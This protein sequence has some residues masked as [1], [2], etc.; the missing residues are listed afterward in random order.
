MAK[1]PEKEIGQD[2][3]SARISPSAMALEE[4]RQLLLAPEQA[5]L[6]KMK[7]RLDALNI[8]PTEV[9]D[10]LSE[11]IRYQSQ[12]N[13]DLKDSLTP[14]IQD[15]FS[16]TFPG[17]FKRSVRETPGIISD[18]VSPILVPTLNKEFQREFP[19]T[20]LRAVKENPNA[21]AEAVSPIIMSAL[22]KWIQKQIEE[23]VQVV[24]QS[25]IGELVQTVNQALE[26]ESPIQRLKW[27]WQAFCTGMP[28][29]DIRQA[30]LFAHFKVMHV[31]LIHAKTGILLNRISGRDE[32]D[33]RED[34]VASMLGAVKK[35]LEDIGEKTDPNEN[36]RLQ[37][38]EFQKKRFYIEMGQDALIAV[39]IKQDPPPKWRETIRETLRVI[40]QKFGS[41]LEKFNGNMDGYEQTTPFL[42]QILDSPRN[43][44]NETFKNKKIS[45]SWLAVAGVILLLGYW[46][47]V[48]IYNNYIWNK[49]VGLVQDFDEN[50][51][52]LF[53]TTV[54]KD[55]EDKLSIKG[56]LAP[57]FEREEL[58]TGIRKIGESVG[59]NPHSLDF[60]FTPFFPLSPEYVLRLA[61]ALLAPPDSVKLL[62]IND[63][64]L[65]ASGVASVAW[66]NDFRTRAKYLP[67]IST[68]KEEKL[69][70]RGQRKMLELKKTIESFEL[71][72]P[73]G[74]SI[75]NRDSDQ[76][77]ETL[78]KNIVHLDRI[79]DEIKGKIVLEIHGHA[80]QDG[81]SELNERISLQRAKNLKN[82]LNLFELQNIEIRTKAKGTQF[83]EKFREKGEEKNF[84]TNRRIS[85]HVLTQ[86]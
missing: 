9:G 25:K 44:E 38:L 76:Q 61:K 84:M 67:G 55:A 63:G 71:Y 83:L 51:V 23:K 42:E 5:Q 32:T 22:G 53:I 4:L 66:I 6:G 8:G 77:I 45:K 48:G 33:L 54:G 20:F 57:S 28:Y 31:F 3:A 7:E 21:L 49:F 59:I 39:V 40:H 47:G 17:A 69:H 24:S 34:I 80:S 10:V 14:I 29:E 41:K 82:A 70:Y 78:S 64:V 13:N 75:V 74:E 58:E 30:Y 52:G 85:L 15:E 19:Q 12:K 79:A 43:S 46:I 18:A 16:E 86:E 1:T 50:E 37:V 26:K 62:V 36:D 60:N 72:F 27:R 81:S 65:Q 56:F 11:A 2:R 73:R 35:V 68:I